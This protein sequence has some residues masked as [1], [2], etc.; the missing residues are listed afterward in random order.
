LLRAPVLGGDVYL[1]AKTYNIQSEQLT[2]CAKRRRVWH[3]SIDDVDTLSAGAEVR[4]LAYKEIVEQKRVAWGN[5][6]DFNSDFIV[7]LAQNPHAHRQ[8][9]ITCPT[10]LRNSMFWSLKAGRLMTAQEM[11]IVQGIATEESIDIGQNDEGELEVVVQYVEC[12][13]APALRA[14]DAHSAVKLAGNG[15]HLAVAGFIFMAALAASR[16]VSVLPFLV[17]ADTQSPDGSQVEAP[18]AAR[19]RSESVDG[20]PE[21]WEELFEE[22][23]GGAVEEEN[24]YGVNDEGEGS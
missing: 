1:M 17:D 18:T 10:M 15:M 19:A 5:D 24:D 20:S 7:D 21:L 11:F 13:V 4:L 14:L 8:M 6:S 3:P 9:G 2:R 23:S 12:P 22:L 16:D